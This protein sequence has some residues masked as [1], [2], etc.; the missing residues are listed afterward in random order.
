VR[1]PYGIALEMMVL[2]MT[3]KGLDK[4]HVC[5]CRSRNRVR[6]GL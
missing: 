3:R 4:Y 1:T 5:I 2:S 6:Q